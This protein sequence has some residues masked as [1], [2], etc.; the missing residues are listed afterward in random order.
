MIELTAALV[1]YLISAVGM[2]ILTILHFNFNLKF[3]MTVRAI[4]IQ[5]MFALFLILVPYVNT[6]VLT[7]VLAVILGHG[8][9]LL[10]QSDF[11]TREIKIGVSK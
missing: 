7:I 1:I 10:Y 2:L 8:I 6:V 9:Y 3:G 11:L 4:I 5:A